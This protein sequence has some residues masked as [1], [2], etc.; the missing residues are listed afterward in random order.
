MKKYIASVPP[1]Q[2]LL[3]ANLW[4]VVFRNISDNNQISPH[5]WNQ[6]SLYNYQSNHKAKTKY[7]KTLHEDSLL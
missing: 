1:P 4:A 6:I 3:R 2:A 7:N 5:I